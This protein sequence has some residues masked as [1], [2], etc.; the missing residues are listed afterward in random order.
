MGTALCSLAKFDMISCISSSRSEASLLC[1]YSFML[2]ELEAAVSR[3]P[4]LLPPLVG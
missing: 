4:S 1:P 3:L 2:R